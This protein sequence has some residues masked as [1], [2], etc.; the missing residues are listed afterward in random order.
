METIDHAEGVRQLFLDVYGDAYPIALYYQPEELLS[1]QD[2]VSAVALNEGNEVVGHLAL[3]HSCPSRTLQ[4]IGAG[5]VRK[6]AR[7]GGLLGRLCDHLIADAK[8][9]RLG[10]IFGESVCNHLYSQRTLAGLD[11][12]DSALEINLMPSEAYVQEKSSDGR[13]SAALSFLPVCDLSDTVVLPRQYE[14]QLRKSYQNLGL[15]RV[16]SLGSE[17]AL[18]ACTEMSVTTIEMAALAR[19]QVD[20]VGQDFQQSLDQ[21]GQLTQLMLGLHLD[22]LDFAVEQANAAGFFFGGLLP[23]WLGVDTLLMQKPKGE[24]DWD[25]IQLLSDSAKE[26]LAFARADYER[27]SAAND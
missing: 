26:L 8:R 25:S 6:D 20:V 27:C 11:F 12:V 15:E 7:S 9:R 22:N 24:I 21:P 14:S 16:L 10:L 1:N 19:V 18:P 4:E 5:L 13:V 2:T 3:Y 17:V 23:R